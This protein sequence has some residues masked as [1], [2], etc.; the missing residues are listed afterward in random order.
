MYK[1]LMRI[2]VE[3]KAYIS[4]PSTTEIDSIITFFEL[5]KDQ[6]TLPWAYYL[7]GRVH[8]DHQDMLQALDYYQLSLDYLRPEKDLHLHSLIHSQ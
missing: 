8:H 7:G 5:Y 3:D 2:K 1:R 4:Q 6:E